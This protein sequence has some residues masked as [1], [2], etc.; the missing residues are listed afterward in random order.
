[1]IS[2]GTSTGAYCNTNIYIDNTNSYLYAN[3]FYQNSS[4]LLK[5]NIESLSIS[6]IDLLNQVDV[7]KFHYLN[8]LVNPHIGFIAEDTP[9][10]LSTLNKNTMDTNSVVGVLIKAVQELSEQI[11]KLNN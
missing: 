11:K 6:A 10:E 4:R 7:V 8:D 1:L 2:N 9:E 3:A 5:T